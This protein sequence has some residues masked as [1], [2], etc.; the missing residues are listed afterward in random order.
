VAASSQ[1]QPLTTMVA[2]VANAGQSAILLRLR[3][4][5]L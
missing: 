4:W 5:L 2:K 1:K 3:K